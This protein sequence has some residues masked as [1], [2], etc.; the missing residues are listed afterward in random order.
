MTGAELRSWRERLGLSQAQ[1]A[2]MLGTDQGWISRAEAG[3]TPIRNPV[4]LE[5]ALRD[6]ERE[7]TGEE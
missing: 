1:L 6:I 7:L 5:R 3:K 2:P 4:M